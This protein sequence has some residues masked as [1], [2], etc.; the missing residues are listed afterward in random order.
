M[1]K[2]IPIFKPLRTKEVCCPSKVAS[3]TTSR[4]QKEAQITTKKSPKARIK[5][6]L[7]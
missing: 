3:R 2:T 6:P 4:H 1:N 5:P 7:E